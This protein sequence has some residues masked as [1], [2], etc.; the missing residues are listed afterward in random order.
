[1][2]LPKLLQFI[3]GLFDPATKLLDEIITS[4]DEKQ[5]N[6]NKL[7]ELKKDMMNIQSEVTNKVLKYESQVVTAKSSTLTA[8]LTG[9]KLQKSWRPILMLA[10]G[11]II[12]YQFFIGP[13]FG[14]NV[15]EFLP[16]RFWTLLEL[17][18]GG[19]IAGRSL[20]KIV[21][22]VSGAITHS[23][24]MADLEYG[25]KIAVINAPPGAVSSEDPEL[26]SKRAL[27][28]LKRK[29]RGEERRARRLS[30]K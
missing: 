10:F 26:I 12:I 29:Q 23:K 22:T 2:A 4:K 7:I 13:L 30:N 19:Y 18:I 1:M 27:R 11:S 9:N 20:E 8:E 5:Q 21:P 24:R 15:I 28:R 14:L 6:L 17:G 25:K 3:G 16:D